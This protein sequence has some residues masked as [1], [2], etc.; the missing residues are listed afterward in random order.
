MI[1]EAKSFREDYLATY[2][3]DKETNE[4]EMLY[5]H[6]V[7]RLEASVFIETLAGVIIDI[8]EVQSS[9]TTA[10]KEGMTR[11]TADK[12]IHDSTSKVKTDE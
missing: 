6:K 12:N 10:R 4:V 9:P 8:S 2:Y 3:Y 7:G 5:K 11:I 1:E